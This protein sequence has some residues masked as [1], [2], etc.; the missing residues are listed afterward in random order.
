MSLTVCTFCLIFTTKTFDFSCYYPRVPQMKE[1]K[2][3]RRCLAQNGAVE[4]GRNILF[5]IRSYLQMPK[6]C[7]ALYKVH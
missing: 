4:S 2:N 3:W 1:F 6:V 5:C 7:I